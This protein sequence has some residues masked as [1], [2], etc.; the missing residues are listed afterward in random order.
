MNTTIDFLILAALAGELGLVAINTIAHCL[1]VRGVGTKSILAACA[2]S[3]PVWAVM[4]F[5]LAGELNFPWQYLAAVVMWMGLS[6]GVKIGTRFS[7]GTQGVGEGMA[8]R[9][10]FAALFAVLIDMVVFGA[11]YS[12]QLM[13]TL[14]LFFVGGLLLHGNR[15]KMELAPAKLIKVQYKLGFAAGIAL[16]EVGAFA[17]FKYAASLQGNGYAH[18]AV[19]MLLASAMYLA[20]GAKALKHDKKTG[21]MSLCAIGGFALLAV[22]AGTANGLALAGLPVAL[23]T[24]FALLRGAWFAMC[25]IKTGTVPFNPVTAAGI[26]LIIAALISTVMITSF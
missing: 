22:V 17:V 20:F 2:L 14:G 6:Y 26:V 25:D 13:I 10:V 16:A 21:Y 12:S 19:F 5:C 18:V 23:F 1:R 3:L 24:M 7:V 4:V 9:F 8:M 15:F 11:Q